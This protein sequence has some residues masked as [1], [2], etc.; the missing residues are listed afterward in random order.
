MPEFFGVPLDARFAAVCIA[1]F[2]GGFMRGFVGFGGAL[3]SI[4]V[5]S[6][7]YDPR[8]AVAAM[9]IVGIP[10]LFQLLPDAIR[11][12]EP[13]IVLPISLAILLSAPVGT[14]V[15][16][17]TSPALMK[18]VI[19][20]LVVLMVAMLARGW[21]LEG[22]VG[23]PVLFGAGVVS[24]LVQGSAGIGGPPVVAVA[25]SRPGPP[26]QQRGNV[27]ALMTAVSIS[28]LLPLW[29]FGL[30]TRASILMGLLLAPVY[31]G[32]TYAGSRY[33]ASSGAR[34]YRNAALVM[35]TLIGLSTL[36]AA[37]RDYLAS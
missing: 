19:S 28:T 17:I 32:S 6:L 12:S 4:P 2:V 18:I 33:F 3:V 25:L 37:V 30:F 13:P 7:A 5:M 22:H 20:V 10:S 36:I 14:W 24:G 27:L 15:L 31:L 21:R 23:R 34:Y 9:T 11:T 26:V 29:Y 16:V 8:L 1:T 35:L